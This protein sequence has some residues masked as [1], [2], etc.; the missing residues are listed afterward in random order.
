MSKPTH[1]E[2]AVK[3]TGRKQVVPAHWMDHPSLSE[4]FRRLPSA[5]S[6]VPVENVD[7]QPVEPA[8]EGEPEKG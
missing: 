6:R 2:V 4:P 1:V 8:L 7:P 3:A 5:K